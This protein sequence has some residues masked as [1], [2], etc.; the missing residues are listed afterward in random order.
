ML[1]GT[2]LYIIVTTVSLARVGE[3]CIQGGYRPG[4]VPFL[5]LGF[6]RALVISAGVNGWQSW[7]ST[8]GLCLC[9]RSRSC[10]FL[11]K[12]LSCFL[13]FPLFTSAVATSD[14]RGALAS[15]FSR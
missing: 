1:I 11:V 3:L 2:R 9:S 12:G 6:L 15:L 5:L 10:T 14:A 13:N 8:E 7:S 4:L